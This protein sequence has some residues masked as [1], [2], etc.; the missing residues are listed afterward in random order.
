MDNH[1]Q[2]GKRRPK[3]VILNR[4]SLVA[5]ILLI[6]V[7]II[8]STNSFWRMM[9]PIHYQKNIQSAAAFAK[10]DPLLIASV[11]RVESKFQTEDVSHA[12]AVGLMQLMPN[13]AQW[14][15]DTIRQQ[16]TGSGGAVNRLPKDDKQ[17]ASPQYNILIGSWYVQ[18]LIQQ[19]HGN[20][21]AAVAAYNAGPKRVQDWLRSGTWDGKLQDIDQIPVGE[22][23]HFVDRVFYNYSLYKK[24]YGHDPAWNT[25]T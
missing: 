22:T 14:I 11:I 23:R 1:S 25:Q 17:L 9:Y 7:L 4:R 3:F 19:F 21:T 2:P 18:S 5:A 6:A 10:V 15:A 24:I 12:G 8:I 16:T 20:V 13:T